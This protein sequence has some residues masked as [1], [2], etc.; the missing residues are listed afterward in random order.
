MQQLS[1]M[2]CLHA[3]GDTSGSGYSRDNN[4]RSINGGISIALKSEKIIYN[5]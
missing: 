5:L 4:S 3:H 1:R 2:V